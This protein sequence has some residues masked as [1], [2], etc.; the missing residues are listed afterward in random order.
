M[1]NFFI[2]RN[3][4]TLKIL[5]LSPSR[6]QD[7][8]I[9]QPLKLQS[10]EL[11]FLT[12]RGGAPKSRHNSYFA[13]ST[14]L[15]F[16]SILEFQPLYPLW[17]LQPLYPLL[18]HEPLQLFNFFIFLASLA[19]LALLACVAFKTPLVLFF[20]G[21]GVMFNSCSDLKCYFPLTFLISNLNIINL[22]PTY[23]Q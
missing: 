19:S 1:I 20:V 5:L 15:A 21:F 7:L 6:P 12:T 16:F 18:R 22:I 10:Q 11:S 14:V 4:D 13:F 9:Q 8:G 23:I 2:P 17:P 3:H